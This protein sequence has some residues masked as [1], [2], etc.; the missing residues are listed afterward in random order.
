[1]KKLHTL[2]DKIE[3]IV[4]ENKKLKEE[5]LE[6]KALQRQGSKNEK[7]VKKVQIIDKRPSL[8]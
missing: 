5:L 6:L 8:F 7:K 2:V 1:M 3:S 4:Q